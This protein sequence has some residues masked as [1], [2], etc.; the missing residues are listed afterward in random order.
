MFIS[1]SFPVTI[2]DCDFFTVAPNGQT[3]NER[4]LCYIF[5]Q[6]A[7]WIRKEGPENTTQEKKG[8]RGRR[9]K[10]QCLLVLVCKMETYYLA[11]I[12]RGSVNVSSGKY[13]TGT[14]QPPYALK[15]GVREGRF[16]RLQSTEVYI[17]DL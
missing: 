8:R 7:A 14:W 16:R 2:N 6:A 13:A 11:R 3:F 17:V 5:L 4:L 10:N 1:V 15:G 9:K 12:K